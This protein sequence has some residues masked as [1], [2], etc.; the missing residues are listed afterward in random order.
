MEMLIL[1]SL[2]CCRSSALDYPSAIAA[3]DNEYER[4]Y[5]ESLYAP[6]VGARREDDSPRLELPA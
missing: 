4:I 5:I 1:T 3:R 6:H 2:L